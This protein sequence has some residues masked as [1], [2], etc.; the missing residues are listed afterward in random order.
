MLSRISLQV[1]NAVASHARSG[2]GLRRGLAT[3]ARWQ[4]PM[5]LQAVAKKSPSLW[6]AA[7]L[8]AAVPSSATFCGWGWGGKDEAA[9]EPATN[10]LDEVIDQAEALY[11]SGDHD[12]VIK[13]LDGR[14]EC[15]CL[16]RN[17]RAHYE[18][19]NAQGD[20]KVK[21]ELMNK[22]WDLVQRAVALDEKSFGAQKWSGIILN[23]IGA[24]E[25]TKKKLQNAFLIKEFFE[26]AAQ[27]NP[28]DATSR[29]LVGIWCYE[30]ASITWV[31]RKLAATLFAD[32]PES[33]YAE[34]LEHLLKAESITPDFWVKNTL[35]IGLAYHKLGNDA[36][37]KKWLEKAA[38]MTV[39]TKEN[40]E[41][42]K[43]AKEKLAKLK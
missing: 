41:F 9:K 28:S 27:N 3:A 42:V 10:E 4:A 33:T 32:P 30:V 24:M 34:A 29:H 20:K 16:W 22:A 38:G 2:Q 40:Q 6:T 5:Q 31:E 25:G 26:K 14:S 12:A 36:E 37:A 15:E 19:A 23:S 21:H 17:A 7:V 8:L 39:H 1:S 35:Y 43:T 11:K 13:L 18:V